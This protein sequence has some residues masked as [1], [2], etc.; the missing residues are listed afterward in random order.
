[1]KNIKH[2]DNE[3]GIYCIINIITLD[4]YIGSSKHIYYRLREHLSKFRKGK[5]HS[6]HMQASFNKYGE[7][8]F[9][10]GILDICEESSLIEKEEFWINQLKP[11]YNKVL[12][13]L[14]RPAC[15]YSS[16]IK[17]KISNSVKL[18]HENGLLNSNR[19][20][21]LVYLKDGSFY[22]EF[23]SI[24]EAAEVTKTGLSSIRRCLIK[25]HK[26]TNGFQFFFK[27]CFIKANEIIYDKK[28][29]SYLNKPI[30]CLDIL[31]NVKIIYK[32][33]KDMC[34]YFNCTW[35]NLNYYYKKQVLYKK[36]Y[37][38]RNATKLG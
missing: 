23:K 19:K 28:D 16:E 20:S 5:H 15:S 33:R 4:F 7:D 12:K 24:K 14:T 38:F 37:I 3:I 13:D 6:K 35:A 8:S 2:C 10:A 36:Q 34:K 26:Q 11:K 30:E 32:S 27:D 25:R 31:N 1:M 18:A 29:G 21:I 22:K 9:L 17:Q